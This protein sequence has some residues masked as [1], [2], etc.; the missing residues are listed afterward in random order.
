LIALVAEW[1]SLVAK[2]VG[3]E[4]DVDQM[5]YEQYEKHKVVVVVAE[6]PQ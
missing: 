4:V 6:E 5:C 2:V 3:S 1:G